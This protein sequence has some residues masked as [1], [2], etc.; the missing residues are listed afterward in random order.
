MKKLLSIAVTV[1]CVTC[2]SASAA[3]QAP[4]AAQIAQAAS[5][6]T[7]LAQLL[8]GATAQQAAEVVRAVIAS[9]LGLGL[10]PE[11]QSARITQI[12]AAGFAAVLTTAITPSAFAAALGKALGSSPV[13]SQNGVVIATVE[14][15]VAAAGG[16]GQAGAALAVFFAQALQTA[17]AANLPARGY[18][19][20]Q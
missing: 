16:G 9:S 17:V 20:Q 19:I 1:V 18:E 13:L 7:A 3:F 8:D 14:S 10:S 6:P 2:M 4:T 12:V 15:A 5:N 11:A